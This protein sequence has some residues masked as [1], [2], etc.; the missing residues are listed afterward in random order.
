MLSPAFPSSTVTPGFARRRLSMPSPI[1]QLL[2]PSRVVLD[3]Q[4]AKRTTAINEVARR[5][6]GMPEL[7]NFPAFY[8]EL[9]ARERLDTTCIGFEVALPHAR[10]DHATAVLMAAGR[11]KDG[12]HFENCNQTVRLVFVLA[13]PKQRAGD[14]LQVVGALCRLLKDGSVRARLMRADTPEAF[15]QVFLEAESAKVSP[16]SR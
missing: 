10:T 11:R 3:I 8:A 13:T 6:D 15:V 12:I 5:L 16:T 14:Y 4:S 1:S 2:D 9:L 7:T